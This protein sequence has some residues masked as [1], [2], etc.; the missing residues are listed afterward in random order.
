VTAFVNSRRDGLGLL[1]V[2]PPPGLLLGVRLGVL[3]EEAAV[4]GLGYREWF[5]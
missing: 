5:N 4:G 1:E 3:R 2:L